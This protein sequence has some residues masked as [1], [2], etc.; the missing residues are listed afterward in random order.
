MVIML[1]PIV[2]KPEK[3]LS[4]PLRVI[5]SAK[6]TAVLSGVL[7][8][9]VGGPVVGVKSFLGGGTAAGLLKESPKARAFVKQKI[10]S[11][12]KTGKEL[13]KFI[14]DPSRLKPKEDQTLG[15]KVLE[16][17]KKAGL[18][19]AAGA[20]AVGGAA[21]VKKG[22]EK[23]KEKALLPKSIPS[24]PSQA[25][26]HAILPAV[27]SITPSQQPLGAMQKEKPLE[28][29]SAPAAMPN[30]KITNKPEINISFKKSRKFINQQVLVKNN[31]TRR[32][33]RRAR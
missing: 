33:K 23:V 18:I 16:A 19:G 21:L 31:G 7:G 1:N 27:P 22:L 4:L 17:G 5:T 11:P 25:L 28:A 12:E 9:L 29:V 14:E 2:L 3:K 20:A 32:K 6:T 24:I 30:I 8:T 15:S 10:L 26:P 13:G